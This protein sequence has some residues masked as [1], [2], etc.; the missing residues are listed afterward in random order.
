MG[1]TSKT[2]L[3]KQKDKQD[4]P[5][6]SM[7]TVAHVIQHATMQEG[8]HSCCTP[9]FCVVAP[10]RPA[11]NTSL[12]SLTSCC[13]SKAC[14]QHIPP[15]PHQ[16]LPQQGLRAT[17]LSQ[18]SPA[19][20]PA[21][22]MWRCATVWTP[23]CPCRRRRPGADTRAGSREVHGRAADRHAACSVAL[24]SAQTGALP[25]GR[26][27]RKESYRLRAVRAAPPSQPAKYQPGNRPLD[28]EPS[29]DITGKPQ[30]NATPDHALRIA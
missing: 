16:L 23:I 12:P 7:P 22:P 18:A 15:K 29:A 5:R 8:I 28:A 20:A 2:G 17:H 27:R 11:C 21:S 19:A 9:P 6:T 30:R 10:A 4:G 13:P 3:T 25:C 24:A 14:V 26:P 1:L